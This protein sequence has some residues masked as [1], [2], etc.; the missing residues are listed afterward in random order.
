MT[1]LTKYYI[2]ITLFFFFFLQNIVSYSQATES[3]FSPINGTTV[4]FT[5]F[6]DAM[7]AGDK[8]VPKDGKTYE[9]R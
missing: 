8:L 6:I 1:F 3:I 7:V 9:L 4:S 5:E 2:R